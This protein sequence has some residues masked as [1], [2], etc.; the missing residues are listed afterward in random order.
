MIK[1]IALTGA[2]IG[3]LAAAPAFAE[4]R[5]LELT[6]FSRIHVS[7]GLTAKLIQ[8][9]TQSVTIEAASQ[10]LIDELDI[11]VEDG[12]LL[13]GATKNGNILDF[14]FSGGLVGMMFRENQPARLTI[15]VPDLTAIQVSAGA[16]LASEGF[17]AGNLSVA[18]HA[19]ANIHLDDV[20]ADVLHL[21]SSSGADLD[22][23]GSCKTLNLEYSTGSDIDASGLTCEN[24]TVDGSTGADARVAASGTVTG[25]VSTGADLTLFGDASD[26]NVQ[27]S[28]GGD[29]NMR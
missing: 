6:S 19:G 4:S 27:A 22:I 23:F 1:S 15:A 14:I 9:D 3:A 7:A 2:A 16:D 17:E 21:S 20:K 25:S 24:V 26:I 28:T 11:R 5:S 12:E 18:A 10:D 13:A 29:V 8:A